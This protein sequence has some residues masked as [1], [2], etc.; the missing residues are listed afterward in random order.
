MLKVWSIQADPPQAVDSITIGVVP[1]GFTETAPY[2]VSPNP[3]VLV[4]SVA[5]PDDHGD[6]LIFGP[7]QK[8]HRSCYT[9]KVVVRQGSG[10]P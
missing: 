1:P 8:P 6:N 4:A 2:S 3:G 10:R 9:D 7:D 5:G